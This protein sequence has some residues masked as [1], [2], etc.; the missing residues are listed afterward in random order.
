MKHRN[1]NIWIF[2][3]NATIQLP[4]SSSLQRLCVNMACSVC[5]GVWLASGNSLQF[6]ISVCLALNFPMTDFDGNNVNIYFHNNLIIIDS[7]ARRNIMNLI[8]SYT[9][10][11]LFE[12]KKKNLM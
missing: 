7:I 3:M 10:F 1:V 12:Q 2:D 9:I 6:P 5:S 4:R 8:Q 11:H